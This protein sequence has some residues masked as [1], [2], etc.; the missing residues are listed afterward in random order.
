[1]IQLTFSQMIAINFAIGYFQGCKD[2]NDK[3]V[4]NVVSLLISIDDCSEI[5]DDEG[6]EVKRIA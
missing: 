5:A 6:K 4:K 2:S 1:M 3:I